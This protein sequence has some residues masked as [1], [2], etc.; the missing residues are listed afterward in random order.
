MVGD[1]ETIGH[2]SAYQRGLAD[3]ERVVTFH[4]NEGIKHIADVMLFK[5][6][7]SNAFRDRHSSRT[8]SVDAAVAILHVI[9]YQLTSS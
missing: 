1:Q 3:L 5:P 6:L 9:M 4:G 7:G 8:A 2:I